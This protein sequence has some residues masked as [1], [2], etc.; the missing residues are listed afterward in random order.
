MGARSAAAYQLTLGE[1][2]LAIGGY[3]GSDPAP[4]LAQFIHLAGTGQV[5]W[6]VPGG[7]TGP[8][9]NQILDW[10]R[11]HFVPKVAD[12]ISLYDVG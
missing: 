8:S 12:G 1:P 3:Q 6:F 9:A 5:H 10:A 11:A 2:V 7:V 4:T